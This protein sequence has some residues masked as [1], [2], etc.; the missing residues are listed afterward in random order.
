MMHSSSGSLFVFVYYHWLPMR[1][2]V[3]IDIF[4]S[5]KGT[6]ILYIASK[7]VI[8]NNNYI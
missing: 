6:N 1:E 7:L 3:A 5:S 2:L 8:T 4:N